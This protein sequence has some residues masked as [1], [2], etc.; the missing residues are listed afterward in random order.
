MR[1]AG[2]ATALDLSLGVTMWVNEELLDAGQ[3]LNAPATLLAG[4]HGHCQVI[5]G[6]VVIAGSTVRPLDTSACD[7]FTTLIERIRD[8][9]R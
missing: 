3:H 6:S 9:L 2:Y 8:D 7:H 4:Q 1:C 5:F